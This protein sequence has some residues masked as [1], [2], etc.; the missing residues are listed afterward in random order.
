MYGK[1]KRDK[2]EF[3][4]ILPASNYFRTPQLPHRKHLQH[5]APKRK[6]L[7][8]IIIIHLHKNCVLC[9]GCASEQGLNN[10][11]KDQN[12]F[13]CDLAFHQNSGLFKSTAIISFSI[14]NSLN[15]TYSQTQPNLEALT[16]SECSGTGF[17]KGEKDE[18]VVKA[19]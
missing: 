17:I 15:Q 16:S 14:S 18:E 4:L 5:Q 8:F 11:I 3:L 19:L 9:Q 13:E 2:Q 12:A 1:I 10:N 7:L 6:Y